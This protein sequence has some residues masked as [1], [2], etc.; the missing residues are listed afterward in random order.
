[1]LVESQD[2]INNLREEIQASQ[3]LAI[4]TETNFTDLYK[5]RYCLGVSFATDKN[6]YYIPVDHRPWFGHE[7]ANF[8]VPPDLFESFKGPIIFHNAAFDLMVLSKL[9]VTIPTGNIWDTMLMS[10]FIN[11]NVMGSGEGHSLESLALRYLKDEKKTKLSKAMHSSWDKVPP[12]VMATYAE[13]DAFLTRDLYHILMQYMEKDWI[14]QWVEFD[15]DFMLLLVEIMELGLPIDRE[16]CESLE[17]Q[18]ADRMSQILEAL[19]FDPAKPD[20]LHSKLFGSPPWGLGLDVPSRTPK[21]K[22]QVSSEYLQSVGHPVTALVYEYRKLGKQKSS[23]FSAY[24]RLTS[25]AYPRLHTNFKQHG[26][27]TGRLSGE[28]PNLQQIPREEYKGSNVKDVFRPESGKQLWEIDFRT[29]EYRLMA[30]YCQEPKLLEIF[31]NEG[32]FHQMVANDLGIS[33][34]NAKTVNYAMGYGAGVNTLAKSL[35]TNS[36]KAEQIHMDYRSAYPM[37]F[38]KVIEAEEYANEYGEIAMWNG[39]KR[40]FQYSSEHRKAFNAVV[41]GGAFEIVKR[42]MLKARGGG[43]CISNQVH[44]SIWVNVDGE[45]EV[46]EIQKLMEDWTTEIFDL[47][48]TTDRKLLAQ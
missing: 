4:D 6:H 34:F 22:P 1:M 14:D 24:L 28:L 31:R 39:R 48:F 42:A 43:A 37:L 44:D 2:Q 45:S 33:R 15:R 40:H 12:Y 8:K 17:Q 16:L 20:Q 13:T 5:N 46:I 41:Q 47:K 25:R 11:E 23:Y 19:K 26:T 18:C 38:N 21:G 10:H 3:V 29:I 27:V 32:D 35:G 36:K 30:V 7:H 9:G